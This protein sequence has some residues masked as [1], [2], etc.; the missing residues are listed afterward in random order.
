MA[1]SFVRK[2][3]L[4]CWG[5]MLFGELKLG[6]LRQ[7]EWLELPVQKWVD[8]RSI[9]WAYESVSTTMIRSLGAVRHL[10]NPHSPMNLLSSVEY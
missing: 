6:K 3:A 2:A 10:I 9:I 5:E 4:H 7:T 1:F 8:Q